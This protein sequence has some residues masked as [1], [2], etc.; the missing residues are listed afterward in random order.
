MSISIQG[1]RVF[2]SILEQGSLSAA[3]RRLG[4][5]Q[6]AVSNHLHALEKRFEVALLVRGG[7]VRATPAGECLANH[8]R[9]VL[10]EISNLEEDM[11]LYSAPHG[12]LVVGASTT[13]GEV[14]VPHVAAEFS[15][16]YPDVTL[17]VEIADTEETLKALLEREVEFAIVGR[18]VDHPRLDSWALEQDELV[19]VVAATD[20]LAGS[21]VAPEDLADRP[22]VMREEGSATRQATKEGLATVSIAPRVAME[23]GSNAAVV[24][25]VAEGAGLGVVPVRTLKSEEQV[26]R[27]RVRGLSFLRPFVLVV[28]RDRPLSP[29][30]EAFVGLCTEKESI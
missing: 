3:G 5:T 11:A 28:E 9:R 7:R 19:L 20:P 10:E 14:L 15:A 8:A 17:D 4:L 1:L 25:A 16:R 6:P 30:A 29:A 24:G 13:P 21:E 2:L 26:G 27:L 12:R 23:L 22:F 18:E